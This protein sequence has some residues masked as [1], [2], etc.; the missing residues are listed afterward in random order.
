WGWRPAVNGPYHRGAQHAAGRCHLLGHHARLLD[1]RAMGG[2]G[3]RRS[4][5]TDGSISFTAPAEH[6][7]I[8]AVC[9]FTGS[10]RFSP[11]PGP[12]GETLALWGGGPVDVLP[13]ATSFWVTR[14]GMLIGYIPGA[15]AF[16]NAGFMGVFPTGWI[17]ACQ[18]MVVVRR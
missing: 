10:G 11:P 15:P 13:T 5:G 4:S 3:R 8:F 12:T 1:R 17:D 7:S 6:F 14:E 9:H 18:P 2:D 16:V